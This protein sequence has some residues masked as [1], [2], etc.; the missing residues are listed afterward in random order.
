MFQCV[1]P[2]RANVFGSFFKKNNTNRLNFGT[3]TWP[4]GF[5]KFKEHGRFRLFDW[6]GVEVWILL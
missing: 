5:S 6:F 2:R 4:L 1:Q 3:F